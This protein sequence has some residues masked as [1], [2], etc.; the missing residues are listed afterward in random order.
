MVVPYR[1][2]SHLAS[3]W[4]MAQPSSLDHERGFLIVLHL[5]MTKCTWVSFCLFAE[6]TIFFRIHSPAEKS[7]HSS[8]FVLFFAQYRINPANHSLGSRGCNINWSP[9]PQLFPKNFH[10]QRRAAQI[11][12]FCSFS[13]KQTSLVLVTSAF[14]TAELILWILQ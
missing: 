6:H 12:F 1:K 3:R 9:I 8:Q 2:E 7:V 13:G 11:F 14:L 4:L 10:L 5:S